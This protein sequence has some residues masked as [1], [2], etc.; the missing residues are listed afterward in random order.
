M[1]S[2]VKTITNNKVSKIVMLKNMQQTNSGKWT[3]KTCK[4]FLDRYKAPKVG[5]KEEL[6]EHCTLIVTLESKKLEIIP[7]YSKVKFKNL[8]Q[9]LELNINTNRAGLLSPIGK[10]LLDPNADLYINVINE[11]IRSNVTESNSSSEE[12]N[13]INILSNKN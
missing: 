10:N 8:R 6:Q 12:I 1:L 2:M 4:N 5:K 9:T 3:K 13:K 11:L 7:L